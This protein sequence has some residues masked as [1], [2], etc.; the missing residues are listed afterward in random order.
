MKNLLY[1]YLDA[2]GGL[3]MLYNHD[4][5]FTNATRLNDPFDCHPSLIDF[6]QIPK[7][8]QSGWPPEIIQMIKAESFRRDHERTWLCSL[9]KVYDEL[10]MWSYYNSHKGICI[11][12][13]MDK[14][15]P[16]L[17]NM[18]GDVMIG[19]MK[20]EVQYKDII[21]KP[22]YFKAKEDLFQYQLCTKGKAWKHEQEVRLILLDPSPVYMKL[23]S[24]QNDK[25]G[26]INWKDVHA[27]GK[28]SGECFDS[29]YL[30]VNITQEDKDKITKI[31][32]QINPNI[33]LY[34]MSID[35]N[36]FKLKA[37][38]L[39]NLPKQNNQL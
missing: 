28:L 18:Y 27:F 1:K 36:A 34:Q 8:E 10:L 39:P 38:L 19:C 2:N 26:P 17:D 20:L 15:T 7:K 24:G 23:L 13:D 32:Q 4:L 33:K 14:A 16:F 5:M 12:I 3:S 30:G 37:E 29:V 21:N 6:T 25:K 11:G 9:S 35:P 31:A 22:D